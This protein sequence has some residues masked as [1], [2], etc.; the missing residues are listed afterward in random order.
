MGRTALVHD[1]ESSIRDVQSAFQDLQVRPAILQV[2]TFPVGP[3]PVFS[4]RLT[5]LQVFSGRYHSQGQDSLEWHRILSATPNLVELKLWHPQHGDTT[6]H[7]SQK[8]VSLPSLKKLSL[9][10][11][12]VRLAGLFA[13]SPLPSLESLLLDSLD[14][15]NKMSQ[16]IA[17]IALVSPSLSDL[18]IGSMAYDPGS[19]RWT[20]PLLALESLE[21]ITFFEIEWEEIVAVLEWFNVPHERRPIR[22]RFERIYDI[23]LDDLAELEMSRRISSTELVDC[24]NRGYNPDGSPQPDYEDGSNYSD[25]TS[26]EYIYESTSEESSSGGS[27]LTCEWSSDED[28]EGE[29]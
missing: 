4:P 15:H 13:L 21:S 12:F 3:S 28:E 22:V 5:V 25:G 26:F 20:K 7:P 10:G 27:E 1:G 2:D 8:P 18:S 6:S 24:M 14:P 29:D 9:T 23:N 19:G 11:L 17:D 16:Q